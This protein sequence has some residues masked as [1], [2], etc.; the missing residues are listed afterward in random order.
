MF[1]LL[2]R[3]WHLVE[4][5]FYALCGW[6]YLASPKYRAATRERWRLKPGE[7]LPEVLAM[8]LGVGIS[9]LIA[10]LVFGK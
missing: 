4:A 2:I 6:L 3:L 7:K 1:E 10:W 9:L 5:V 8:S